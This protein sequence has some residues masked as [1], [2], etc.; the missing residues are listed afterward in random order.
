MSKTNF[1]KS[2]YPKKFIKK[3]FKTFMDNIHLVIETTLAVK[4]KPPVL[5]LSYLV[6]VSLLTSIKLKKSSKNI[7]SC[8]LQTVFKN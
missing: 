6:S 1:L 4:K 5:V 2:G 8:K 7:L 3:Y